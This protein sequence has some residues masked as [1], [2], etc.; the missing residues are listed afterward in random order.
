MK[1]LLMLLL[2]A[3]IFITACNKKEVASLDFDVSANK[4]SI[5]VGDTVTFKIS[6]NPEQLTFYSGEKGNAYENRERT[7]V[8]AKPIMSFTSYMQFGAQTNTL[9]VLASTD[10]NGVYNQS[11][12]ESATWT[13]ITAQLVLSTGANN[14]ASG[15]ID[16]T[17]FKSDKPV[18]I[19]FKY[20]GTTG[21]TQRTWTIK[22]FKINSITTTGDAFSITKLADAGWQRVNFNSS[23][24]SWAFTATQ[25][26]FAGGTATVASN[27][28]W[29]ITKPL[30]LTK[31][32]PD[33]GVALKNSSTRITEYKHVFTSAGTFKTT[34]IGANVNVYGSNSSLKALDITVAP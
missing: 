20:T 18:Y 9:A 14:T 1:K 8:D 21:S 24:R 32:S 30:F 19:A 7:N 4:T 6:G 31:V 13:D 3:T 15:D 22:D 11:D 16:L 28:G 2:I 17:S 33:R 29:A 25:L 27:L 26:Q 10:F 23:P 12:V 5:K 34:F